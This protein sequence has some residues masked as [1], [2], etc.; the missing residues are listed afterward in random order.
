VRAGR[1][2]QRGIALLA[3]LWA[4]AVL[5]VLAMDVL[6][7]SRREALH[8]RDRLE[9]ARLEAAAEAGLAL[10]VRAL[11]RN[12]P[13]AALGPHEFDGSRILVGL[14][15][16]AGKVDLNA[17]APELLRALLLGLGVPG[18]QALALAA[19]IIDWRDPDQV[20]ERG[21]LE[22]EG[23]RQQGRAVPPRDAEFQSVAEMADLAGMTPELLERLA[24]LVTVHHRR[25]EPEFA[26]AAPPVRQALLLARRLQAAADQ[27]EGGAA[28]AAPPT[29]AAASPR[30]GLAGQAF[31]LLIAVERPEGGRLR[32]VA[33]VRLTGNPKEPYWLHDWR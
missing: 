13:A 29:P 6:L 14:E 1:A 18:G 2:G 30:Q 26:L 10:A 4:V 33:V 15:P 7:A 32:R 16:E 21:G 25:P 24:P 27:A 8:G 19:A 20:P 5:A 9:H 3:V 28:T 12:A 11:L 23:Y 31:T 22:L 17:A